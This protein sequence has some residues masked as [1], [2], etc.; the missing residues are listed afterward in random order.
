MSAVMDNRLPRHRFTVD[1]YY[2]MAEVGLLAANARVELIEGQIIDKPYPRVT[3]GARAVAADDPKP[4]TAVLD[5][6][7][8]GHRFTVDE[9]YRMA[10][11]GLLDRE[12]RVE[13]IEGEIIDMPAPGSLSLSVCVT[14]I[15]G[16]LVPPGNQRQSGRAK[17]KGRD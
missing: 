5:D 9:L 7:L 3:N 14:A 17:E 2:R 16:G 15:Q 8:P 11:V 6:W 13:L 4:M 12:A 1:E 10:E